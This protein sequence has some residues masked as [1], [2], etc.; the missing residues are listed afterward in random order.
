M[1]HLETFSKNFHFSKIFWIIHKFWFDFRRKFELCGWISPEKKFL[2]TCGFLQMLRIDPH[3]LDL[4]YKKIWIWKKNFLQMLRIDPHCV[5]LQYKK[6]WIWKKLKKWPKTPQKCTNCEF[7]GW[8]RFFSEN[9]LSTKTPTHRCLTSCKKL[10]NSVE[11]FSLTFC[12]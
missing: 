5:H 8:S 1:D 3:L 10:E 9:P 2:L 6:I 11:P 12:D 7:Y 4:Q